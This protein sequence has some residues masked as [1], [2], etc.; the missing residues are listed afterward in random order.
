MMM[1]MMVMATSRASPIS[2]TGG[3][4][5]ILEVRE[6]AALGCRRKVRCK[7]GELVRRVRISVGLSG[8]RGAGQVRS[9]GLCNLLVLGWVRLLKLLERAR[10]LRERRKLAAVLRGCERSQTACGQRVA[11]FGHAIALEGA[12]ENR[13]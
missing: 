4:R 8:L 3:I 11:L 10:N 1:V 7:L 13:L 5:Q 9:D 6:L 12:F 2:P